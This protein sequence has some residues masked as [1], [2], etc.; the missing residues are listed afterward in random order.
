ML[1][2]KLFGDENELPDQ[3]GIVQCHVI[4]RWDR[5]SRY[6]NDV[7]RCLWRNIPKRDDV[8]VLMQY[9][10]GDLAVGDLFE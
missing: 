7:L 6:D 9:G 3:L 8:I 2:G 4:D 1:H 10:G 5:L